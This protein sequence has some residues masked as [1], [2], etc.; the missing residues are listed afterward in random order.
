MT[1]DKAARR[2]LLATALSGAAFST[3]TGQSLEPPIA[4]RIAYTVKS[5]QGERVDEYY[6]L[7]DDDPKA[8]RADIMSYLRAEKAY[9]DS[10]TAPLQALRARLVT[11]MRARIKEDDSTVP[12]YDNGFWYWRQFATGAEYPVYLRRAGSAAGMTAGA[13]EEVVLDVPKLAAGKSYYRV[14][15]SAVSPDNRWLAYVE[16]TQGRRMYT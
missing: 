13:A 1:P 3:A 14:G 6:W 5:P 8:K 4:P 16:D 11:E 15:G 2:A 9:A 7:R 10:Y 12:F